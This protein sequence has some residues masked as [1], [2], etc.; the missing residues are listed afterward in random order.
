M[1]RKQKTK[2]QERN[3]NAGEAGMGMLAEHRDTAQLCTGGGRNAKAQLEL[4]LA[5]DANNNKK[6]FYRYLNQKRKIKESTTSPKNMT[7]NLVKKGKDKAEVLNNIF[8]SVYTGNLSS[9]SSRVDEL[10]DR[11]WKSK[12]PPT[13]RSG[14]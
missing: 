2:R 11:D 5:Q 4:S 9:H 1:A 14:S 8:A 3:A 13:K 6:G 7:G 12:V 10:Q